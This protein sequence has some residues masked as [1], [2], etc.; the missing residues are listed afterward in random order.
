MTWLPLEDRRP[1]GPSRPALDVEPGQL[2]HEAHAVFL[3]RVSA[4]GIGEK[5]LHPTRKLKRHL[6][7]THEAPPGSP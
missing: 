5:L 4:P 3:R 6:R 7:K 2:D 1:K